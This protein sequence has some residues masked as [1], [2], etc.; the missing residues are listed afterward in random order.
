[1]GA[2]DIHIQLSMRKTCVEGE[3]PRAT[4]VCVSKC[5]ISSD[6]FIQKS[7]FRALSQK[8][9]RSKS[10][11]MF[12]NQ[13]TAI[14]SPL[15]SSQQESH[16]KV[17]LEVKPNFN[18]NLVEIWLGMTKY[19]LK[20]P[21]H[22][23]PSA[24][25]LQKLYEPGPDSPVRSKQWLIGHIPSSFPEKIWCSSSSIEISTITSTY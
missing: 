1:M 2:L 6:F 23:S 20:C 13:V 18:L 7:S 21:R 17:F 10:A 12:L 22:T 19:P 11:H 4:Q 15:Y 25:P 16:P 8:A 3:E 14:Y 9:I 24:G 5:N